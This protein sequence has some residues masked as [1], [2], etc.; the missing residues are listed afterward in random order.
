MKLYLLAALI[1]LT[2]CS[3]NKTEGSLHYRFEATNADASTLANALYKP[4]P[5]DSYC[6]TLLLRKG[7]KIPQFP[8]SNLN[9]IIGIYIY[10]KARFDPM[11]VRWNCSYRNIGTEC[12][13][14]EELNEW[15]AP[16]LK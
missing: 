16:Y 1:L 15:V 10:D 12:L 8:V 9:D 3:D 14:V 6:Q 11:K 13:N 7:A 4:C 2:A 5:G